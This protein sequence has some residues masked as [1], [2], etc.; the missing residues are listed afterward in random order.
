[1]SQTGRLLPQT[2]GQVVKFTPYHPALFR[3][4]QKISF[5]RF[6]KPAYARFMQKTFN[7][8]A[9]VAIAVRDIQENILFRIAVRSPYEARRASERASSAG[10]VD[11]HPYEKRPAAFLYEIEPMRRSQRYRRPL[12]HTALIYAVH[13]VPPS[14]IYSAM[15]DAGFCQPLFCVLI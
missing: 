3:K 5:R 1:M 6:L 12:S 10:Y 2:A 8:A 14:L 4:K 9:N 7:A 13:L 11:R 15:F